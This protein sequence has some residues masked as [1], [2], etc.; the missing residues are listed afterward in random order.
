M[1]EVFH[2]HQMM[3]SILVARKPIS[4]VCL[5]RYQLCVKLGYSQSTPLFIHN[6][7]IVILIV[8]YLPSGMK[9][10]DVLYRKVVI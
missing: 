9:D 5:E 1:A 6:D 3:I 7:A 4:Y 2:S 8:S 10:S